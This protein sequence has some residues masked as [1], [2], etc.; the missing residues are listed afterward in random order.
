MSMVTVYF[1]VLAR[2]ESHAQIRDIAIEHLINELYAFQTSWIRC[3][4]TS[5]FILNRL[6]I[7]RVID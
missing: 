1:V 5:I 4:K 6:I 2:T 7:N 3:I